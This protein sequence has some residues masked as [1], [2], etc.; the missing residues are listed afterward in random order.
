MNSPMLTLRFHR[1][2]RLVVYSDTAA[3]LFWDRV[4]NPFRVETTQISRNGEPLGNSVG[5]SFFDDTRVRGV[6]Y[7]Y[8]I[9]VFGSADGRSETVVITDEGFGASPTAPGA[10][11]FGITGNTLLFDNDDYYQIQ[12]AETFAT[13]CENIRSCTVEPGTY[14]VI[15][16]TKDERFENIVIGG[17]TEKISV[18]GNTISW[19]DDGWYQVQDAITF[20]NVC[21]GGRSC[22]VSPGNYVVINH[23]EGERFEN[24][25]VEPSASNIEFIEFISGDLA[26]TE[27]L[28][29]N[30]PRFQIVSSNEELNNLYF[31]ALVDTSCEACG[32][33]PLFV[34][35]NVYTVVL[36]AH[37][38]VGSGGFG[39]G[40][41]S[42]NQG[43]DRVRVDIV[44]TTPGD[45]CVV[46]DAFEGPFKLYQLSGTFNDID[47]VERTEQN[48]PC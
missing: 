9:V 44:K 19:P 4:A 10:D 20:E 29:F 35:F 2:L 3:E 24:I 21:N 37:E 22:E 30:Q 39:I 23:S 7:Q 46:T 31:G 18:S 38:I 47:F 13:V 45:N 36:V 17:S 6:A 14:I 5:T 8:E 15:N 16:H 25:R 32:F 40:I 1:S 48:P 34:D 43:P 28:T 27:D 11:G 33:V 42:V 12:N 26:F 41:E